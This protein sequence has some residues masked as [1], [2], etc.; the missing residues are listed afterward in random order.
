MDGSVVVL[1]LDE[2][3]LIWDDARGHGWAP[4][5]QRIDVPMTN[6]RER[7]TYY[8]AIDPVS[9]TVHVI[10]ADTA[11]GNWTM[12]F[13]EY[14]RQE[15]AEKRLLLLWDGAS[16]HRGVEMQEYLEGVNWQLARDEWRVTCMLFAPNAPEQNPIEDV[17]LK[18]KQY[19]R[20]YWWKCQ[21]FKDVMHLFEEAF[22]ILSFQFE[23]LHMY[24]PFLQLI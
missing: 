17:W 3:H 11:N 18:A 23:K 24:L 21:Y 13:V 7:Q 19:V 15:Y 16:Y 20:K 6:F 8:G 12:I 10:P 5:N 1:Y 22:D 4:S 2:C 9:G 14:L